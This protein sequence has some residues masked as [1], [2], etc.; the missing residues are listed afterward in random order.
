M[1][2]LHRAR[3]PGNC[4]REVCNIRLVHTCQT[5]LPAKFT[6]PTFRKLAAGCRPSGKCREGAEKW[7]SRRSQVGHSLWVMELFSKLLMLHQ[8]ICKRK[9]Y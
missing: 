8:L 9:P 5:W 7:M 3:R 6:R 2:R 1:L 4:R